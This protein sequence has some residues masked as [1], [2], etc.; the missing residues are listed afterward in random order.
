ME[1]CYSF[2]TAIADLIDNSMIRIARTSTLQ[3]KDY[4]KFSR[5]FLAA[6]VF[7]RT[8]PVFDAR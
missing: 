6:K 4:L 3:G 2:E 1:I 5:D 8:P 7:F